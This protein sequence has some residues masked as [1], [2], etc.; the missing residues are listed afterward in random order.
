MAIIIDIKSISIE[1][2]TADSLLIPR[3]ENSTI[4]VMSRV[5]IPDI[6]IGMR[7]TR[8]AIAAQIER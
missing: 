8:P 3:N 2:A 5:P 4:S 6:D 1:I 7:V